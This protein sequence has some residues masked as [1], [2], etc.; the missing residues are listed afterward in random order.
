MLGQSAG[1][2]APD[3]IKEESSYQY[4]SADSLRCTDPKFFQTQTFRF[5][6]VGTIKIPAYSALP[7]RKRNFVSVIFMLVKPLASAPVL[8]KLCDSS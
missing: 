2:S 1:V 8:L 6:S 4:M 3:Q 7:K 5:S